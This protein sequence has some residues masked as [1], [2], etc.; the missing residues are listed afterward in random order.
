MTSRNRTL[1]AQPV[2]APAGSTRSQTPSQRPAVRIQWYDRS[3]ATSALT[4]ARL[5]CAAAAP[6]VSVR[7]FAAPFAAS[8]TAVRRPMPMLASTTSCQCMRHGCR[9]G[10]CGQAPGVVDVRTG[11]GPIPQKVI[12]SVEILGRPHCSPAQLGSCT[13]R[14]SSPG[15]QYCLQEYGYGYWL[16]CIDAGSAQY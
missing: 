3:R 15:V 16:A 10:S 9:D 8:S 4:F 6:A 7:A 5:S 14:R 2:S 13:Q 1:R 12:G 11:L